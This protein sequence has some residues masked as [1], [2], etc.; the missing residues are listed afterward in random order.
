MYRYL[1]DISATE[2][3]VCME[4][5]LLYTGNEDMVLLDFR[6]AACSFLPPEQL[7]SLPPAQLRERIFKGLPVDEFNH[8]FVVLWGP[9]SYT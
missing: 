6:L 3:D 2:D 7:A 4:C 5:V 1:L 8:E 9:I